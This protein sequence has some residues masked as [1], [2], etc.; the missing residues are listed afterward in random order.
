MSEVALLT[1]AHNIP[2]TPQQCT[3]ESHMPRFGVCRSMA[4]ELHGATL[5]SE[6][7]LGRWCKGTHRLATVCT[8]RRRRFDACPLHQGAGR[9]SC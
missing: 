7:A 2:S 4:V 8:S 9:Q 6:N 5:G 1:R 3:P